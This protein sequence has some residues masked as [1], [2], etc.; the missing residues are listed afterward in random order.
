[1]GPG[2]GEGDL[3]LMY[4]QILF[5]LVKLVSL[6]AL[7]VFAVLLFT[8]GWPRRIALSTFFLP[9]VVGICVRE[10][11]Q[12]MG[13]PVM[14]WIWILNWFFNPVQFVFLLG[15]LAYWGVPFLIVATLASNKRMQDTK[16]RILVYGG[17]FGTLLFSIVVFGDLWRVTEELLMLSALI[18]LY[19][20]PGTVLGLVI[21]W[22]VGHFSQKSASEAHS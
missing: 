12:A 6:A 1:V 17:F 9:V 3:A 10:I 11:L 21:G 4:Y 15:I 7:I 5:M 13:K 22:L 16:N 20:L 19:I 8:G 2:T 14:P 18:P